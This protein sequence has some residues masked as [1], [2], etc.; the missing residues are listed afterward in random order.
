MPRKTE[1]DPEEYMISDYGNWNVA[2]DYSK[3]MIMKPLWLASEYRKIAYFGYADLLDEL[4]L[5]EY[6]LDFLKMK[7]YNR[8]VNILIEVIENSQF[9]IIPKKDKEL[10]RKFLERL[11]R[12]EKL[13]PLLFK[14]KINQVKKTSE[15]I[16][17][18]EKYDPLLEEVSKIRAEILEPLNRSDLIYTHKEEFDPVAYKKMVIDQATTTG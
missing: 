9:A 2:A 18:K 3:L 5:G 14:T 16:I 1:I 4:A 8:L 10:L 12:I 7:G 6:N 17:V 13:K 11:K 15:V